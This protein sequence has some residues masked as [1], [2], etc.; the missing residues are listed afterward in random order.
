MV[1]IKIINKSPNPLPRYAKPGDS[2]L[3]LR[4]NIGDKVISLAPLERVVVPTG[5]YVDIPEGYE[6]QI[7]PRSGVSSKT[8]MVVVLGTIDSGYTGEIGV[9]IINLSNEVNQIKNNDKIAQM[10]VCKVEQAILEEV[11]EITKETERGNGGFG[12]TGISN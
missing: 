9:I 8:G 5:I 7:R 3:D 4:A 2:G 10:V 6:I 1:V 12:H 11:D